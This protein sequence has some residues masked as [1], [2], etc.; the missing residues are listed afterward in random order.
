MFISGTPGI[1]P[2]TGELAGLDAASQ[3]RQVL[4]TLQTLLASAGCRWGDVAHVNVC[5]RR[6][7]DFEAKNEAYAAACGPHR[8]ART[9]VCAA[10]LPKPGAW[11]TMSLTALAPVDSPA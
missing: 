1:D 11:L 9:V 4:A 3:T 2:G 8:P 5:L 6:V 7:T 10:D